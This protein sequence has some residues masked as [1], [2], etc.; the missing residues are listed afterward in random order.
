MKVSRQDFEYFKERVRYWLRYFQLG[1]W[2]V[3]IT[4]IED[5]SGAHGGCWSEYRQR[6]AIINI[7]TEFEPTG[8]KSWTEEVDHVAFHEAC[9][10][11]L[12][13]LRYAGTNRHCTEEMLE[14]AIH[15][16]ISRLTNTILRLD[17]PE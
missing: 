8:A 3:D 5:T 11:L 17:M 15:G 4:N 14:S 16:V 1:D 12:A 6:Q 9:E 2:D 7:N 13:E 10:L